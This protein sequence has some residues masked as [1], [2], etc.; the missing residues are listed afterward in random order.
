MMNMTKM[1]MEMETPMNEALQFCYPLSLFQYLNQGKTPS[2]NKEI[3]IFASF[4][5]IFFA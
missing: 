3:F 1:E 4:K 5:G 2:K